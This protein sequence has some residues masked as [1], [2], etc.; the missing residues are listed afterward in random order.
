MHHARLQH[1]T[2]FEIIKAILSF[3]PSLCLS[4]PLF[5]CTPSSHHDSLTMPEARSNFDVSRL[6][7]HDDC[8]I[9]DEYNTVVDGALDMRRKLS[10]VVSQARQLQTELLAKQAEIDHLTTRHQ[11]ELSRIQ[12]SA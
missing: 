7:H 3:P 8:D 1:S 4:L 2:G 10:F 6:L 12:K 5:L 9:M 11:Q